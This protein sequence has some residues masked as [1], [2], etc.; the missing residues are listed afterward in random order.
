MFVLAV[1]ATGGLAVAPA[2]ANPPDLWPE[3]V[4][5]SS[6]G[7]DLVE[8]PGPC[9]VEIDGEGPPVDGLLDSRLE[10]FFDDDGRLTI[11]REIYPPTGTT[12][13]ETIFAYDVSART[14]TETWN[15]SGGGACFARFVHYYDHSGRLYQTETDWECDGRLEAIGLR[16][17]DPE[18][19][20]VLGETRHAESGLI[21]TRSSYYYDGDGNLIGE[22]HD[23]THSDD[24]DEVIDGVIDRRVSYA[25]DDEGH[26][27]EMRDDLGMDGTGA[28]GTIE[29][30]KL[31]TYDSSGLLVGTESEY[32]GR[33]LITTLEY[34]DAGNLLREVIT[35]EAGTIITEKI[36]GYECW[37]GF[38]DRDE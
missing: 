18:G 23:L 22:E 3:P 30:T 11:S 5:L 37:A 7:G 24:P 2:S 34:D 1:A 14:I 36:Y 12:S 8:Y 19:N 32:L 20:Q 4:R 9:M 31:Y 13:F 33:N 6:D 26:R 15:D 28:D 38:V 16:T 27:V 21:Q 17:Y 35:N 29:F 10:Y 25:Y